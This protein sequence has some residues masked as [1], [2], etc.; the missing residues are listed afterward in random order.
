[1]RLDVPANIIY[2][3]DTMKALRMITNENTERAAW[4]DG[5]LMM[6]SRNRD[7]YEMMT[8]THMLLREEGSADLVEGISLLLKI[9]GRKII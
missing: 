7:Q 3:I 8:Y 6:I 5:E 1:M 4:T 9:H 2:N